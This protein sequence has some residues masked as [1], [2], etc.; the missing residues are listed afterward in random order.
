M[1]HHPVLATHPHLKEFMAFL[2]Q[3]KA[4]SE[5]GEVLISAAMIDDLLMRTVAAFLIEGASANRLLSGFNA[6]LGTLSARIEMAAALG[7]ISDDEHHDANIIRKVRNEFAHNLPVSFDN[8]RIRQSCAAL[9]LSAK[10]YG[11]VIVPPR[12]QFSTAA[13]A[14]ILNLTNRPHY[15]GEKRLAWQGW[16]Y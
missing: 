6:P 15:V 5:R 2:E 8:P 1:S 12:G 11:D 13:T 9:R 10:D 16:P 4:E 14:L 3:L 7:L